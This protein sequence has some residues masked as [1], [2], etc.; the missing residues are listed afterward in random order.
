MKREFAEYRTQQLQQQINPPQLE[1]Q[2]PTKSSADF[3]DTAENIVMTE[4]S[5]GR[6]SPSKQ[7]KD[8]AE[9]LESLI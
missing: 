4:T 1:S 7:L 6:L 2:E 8:A 3:A 5:S 9:R